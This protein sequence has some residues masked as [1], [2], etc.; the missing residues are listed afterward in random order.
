MAT[1]HPFELCAEPFDGGAAALV[2]RIGADGHS[3][4]LPLLERVGE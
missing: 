1:Q 4:H 3:L 2:A